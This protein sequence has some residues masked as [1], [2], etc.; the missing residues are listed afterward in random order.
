MFKEER[1]LLDIVR[2]EWNLMVH[3]PTIDELDN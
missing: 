1:I 2:Q 3:D